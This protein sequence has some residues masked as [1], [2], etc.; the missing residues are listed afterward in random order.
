MVTKMLFHEPQS[1][2]GEMTCNHDSDVDCIKQLMGESACACRFLRRGQTQA[3]SQA[4]A[5]VRASQAHLKVG[6]KRAPCDIF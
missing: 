5:T 1:V 6:H 2:Q 4:I 3:T